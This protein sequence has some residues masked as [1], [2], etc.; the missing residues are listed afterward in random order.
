MASYSRLAA[1]L[2]KGFPFPFGFLHF[3]A[4]GTC[5]KDATSCTSACFG[6]KKPV[7][8]PPRS[9]RL[10][11][12]NMAE[13]SAEHPPP[14]WLLWPLRGWSEPWQSAAMHHCWSL[15]RASSWGSPGAWRYS[16][17]EGPLLLWLL[18]TKA[19]G[20]LPAWLESLGGLPPLPPSSPGWTS[21][22]EAPLS[23]VLGAWALWWPGDGRIV[24]AG[25]G[26]SC[27]Q[28]GRYHH[29]LSNCS[30]QNQ[31]LDHRHTHTFSV[32]SFVQ[33]QVLHL[34]KK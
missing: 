11:R 19:F 16:G 28:P 7:L 29:D 9:V 21:W 26:L 15:P 22:L 1:V 6:G 23:S 32:S 12:Q 33:P 34:D 27:R 10:P 8:F 4:T 18:P 30:L 2:P 13:N 5:E 14:C 25:I 17:G 24:P 3:S 20:P 31:P